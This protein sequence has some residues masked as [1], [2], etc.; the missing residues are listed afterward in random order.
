MSE[1]RERL[2]DLAESYGFSVAND[3]SED[4]IDQRDSLLSAIGD[5][6]TAT[7]SIELAKALVKADEMAEVIEAIVNGEL[8]SEGSSDGIE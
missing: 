8:E 5:I 6:T 7:T 2:L 3:S 1:D 4:T